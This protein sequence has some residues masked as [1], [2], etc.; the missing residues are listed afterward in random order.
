MKNYVGIRSI[1]AKPMNRLEYNNYRGWVLPKNESGNDEGYLV[2][3]PDDVS[4]HPKH[5]G[6]LS[7]V[8]KKQFE[9]VYQSNGNYSFGHALWLIQHGKRVARK[10]WNDKNMFL[11]LVPGSLFKVDRE[12][13]MSVIGEGVLVNYHGHIDMRTADGTIVPWLCSQTDMLSNDWVVV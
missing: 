3:S 6:Y 13:L 5:S 12:P 8:P 1:T 4:N 2:E 11:F 10:N 7:W 9:S